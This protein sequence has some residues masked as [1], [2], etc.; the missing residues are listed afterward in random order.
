MKH[1]PKMAQ[2]YV[3]APAAPFSDDDA[4]II[5]RELHKIAR[6]HA[7]ND[8]GQLDKK[9]VFGIVESDSKHPLRRF[10]D[11]DESNAARK[12]WI[13]H[14]ATLIRSVRIV[15]VGASPKEINLFTYAEVSS[16]VDGRT[17]TKRTRVLTEDLLQDDPAFASALGF[18]IR[19]IG[20]AAKKLEDLVSCRKTP[21]AIR[22]LCGGL[23]EALD[24]Y[25]ASLSDAA[26]E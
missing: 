2:R 25:A 23:R 8:L 9:L 6:A 12:H 1:R 10:Y 24:G 17:R 13:E 4:Q 19:N 14:T 21:I 16:N 20:H 22:R 5:G 7:I 11:W 3:R 18:H 26:A 15:G